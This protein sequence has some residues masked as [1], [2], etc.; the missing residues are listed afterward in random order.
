VFGVAESQ[1][2]PMQ[3]G[4][5]TL[6]QAVRTAHVWANIQRCL[7]RK[8]RLRDRRITAARVAAALEALHI[9]EVHVNLAPISDRSTARRDH[10]ACE[11]QAPPMVLRTLATLDHAGSPPLSRHVRARAAAPAPS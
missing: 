9:R 3:A 5:D 10:D 8:V 2:N 11:V 6:N 7:M 1:P 4:I